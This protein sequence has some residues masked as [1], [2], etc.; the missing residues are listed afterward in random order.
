MTGTW[1]SAPSYP[2]W[3]F[4]SDCSGGSSLSALGMCAP[5]L[6]PGWPC[7]SF[8]EPPTV[9]SCALMDRMD[10]PLAPHSWNHG[11]CLRYVTEVTLQG[12]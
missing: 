3:S 2:V 10:A 11:V 8:L 5:P 4:L 6:L 9:P 7:P 12:H 1:P